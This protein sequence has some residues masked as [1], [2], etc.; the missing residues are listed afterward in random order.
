ML[1]IYFKVYLLNSLSPDIYI[2]QRD[3]GGK[4]Q[5]CYFQRGE[6]NQDVGDHSTTAEF[7]I[8]SGSLM[9]LPEESQ[10]ILTTWWFKFDDFL[11]RRLISAQTTVWHLKGFR[12]LEQHWD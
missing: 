5:V 8:V 1:R 9:Y 6:A 3:M 11:A 10:M 4:C 12:V 7:H 2:W